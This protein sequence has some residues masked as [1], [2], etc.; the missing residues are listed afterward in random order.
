MSPKELQL[1]YGEYIGFY[2]F[3]PPDYNQDTKTHP[4]IIF[5][6]G[7]GEKGD[8]TTQLKNACWNGVPR[9]RSMRAAT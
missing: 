4:L 5:L 2:Q 6:H 1:R 8:G 7:A 3:L 9:L